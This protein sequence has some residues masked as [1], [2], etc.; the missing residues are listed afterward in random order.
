MRQGSTNEQRS[1]GAFVAIMAAMGLGV[2]AGLR[3]AHLGDPMGA[4]VPAPVLSNLRGRLPEGS[5][6]LADGASVYVRDIFGHDAGFLAG[7]L[8]DPQG[9]HLCERGAGDSALDLQPV[10][11]TGVP[12]LSSLRHVFRHS[13]RAAIPG[14]SALCLAAGL[15]GC[16]HFPAAAPVARVSAPP[17]VIRFRPA[18]RLG[19]GWQYA[20]PQ[21]GLIQVMGAREP[22]IVRRSP[23]EWVLENSV[24]A[25]V[26]PVRHTP[27]QITMP[28]HLP[29]VPVFHYQMA[30]NPW[31]C[32]PANLPC[33]KS[34]H[35]YWSCSKDQGKA[36]DGALPK[37]WKWTKTGP[38]CN[39]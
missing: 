14:L 36:S 22:M 30:S 23:Q 5:G 18:P 21:S 37:G 24:T 34:G 4:G 32:H 2:R 28:L 7:G 15:T 11:A 20:N 19:S 8:R 3:M 12:R 9:L 16:A 31:T 27:G 38:A 10:R 1:K 33:G 39:P 29:A 13:V 6:R 25:P 26:A 17:P 35:A